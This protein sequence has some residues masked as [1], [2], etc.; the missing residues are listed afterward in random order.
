MFLMTFLYT[1]S[2]YYPKTPCLQNQNSALLLSHEDGL[3]VD[4][5]CLEPVNG[6]LDTLLCHGVLLD[7]GLDVVQ[8]RE[9]EH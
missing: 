9:L 4:L 8:R 1:P 5:S 2:I 6:L 3:E 7:D